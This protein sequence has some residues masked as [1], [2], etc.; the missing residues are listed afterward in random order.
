[1]VKNARMDQLI[2]GPRRALFYKPVMFL[3]SMYYT[4]LE[5]VD[6]EELD[7]YV[8]VVIES[9]DGRIDVL[10]TKKVLLRYIDMCQA[11]KLQ[12]GSIE[13]HL[14]SDKTENLLAIK[15]QEYDLV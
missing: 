4:A 2:T 8:F 11:A 5:W 3:F 7:R 15:L 6:W 10:N 14:S 1:M 9:K 13:I 12:K